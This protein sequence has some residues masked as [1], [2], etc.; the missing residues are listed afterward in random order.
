[1]PCSA[2]N[3]STRSVGSRPFWFLCSLL[4]LSLL[5]GKSLSAQSR[6]GS[7]KSVKAA[8]GQKVAGQTIVLTHVTVID[9]TGSAPRKDVSVSIAGGRIQSIA[10]K[11]PAPRGVLVIPAKGKFVIPG[12][13][14]MHIHL[15]PPEIFFPMLLANGITGVRDMF[16]GVPLNTIR[17][18]RAQP[19][20]PHIVAGGFIDG[21][22]MLWNGIPPPGAFAV[23]NPDQARF[24]VHAIAGSGFDFVKVYSSVPRDAYFALA[25][26]ARAVGI[27]F[28]GHVPEEVSPTEASDAGQRSQEHLLNILLACSTHEEELRAERVRTMLDPKMSG[29][30]RMRTL[31]FPPTDGLLDSYSE[32]K[33][34]TLFETFVRNGTWQTPTLVVLSGFARMGDDDFVH[35]SRR[36][37]LLTAWKDAW[38]PRKTFFLRDLTPA[39]WEALQTRIRALLARHEKLVGDMHRAGVQFLAGTDTNGY[40][41][42]FPGSGLH[43]EL[44]L[45]V[46]SGLSP[47]QALQS[48]TLNPARYFGLE[49]EMGTVEAGKIAD[50]VL[51]NADPLTD[52]HNSVKI[53]AVVKRGHYYSRPD[54]DVLAGRAAIFA[55]TG[56]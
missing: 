16:S 52:I 1:V 33:A 38:D 45:L 24:A 8:S 30:Q 2:D 10:K 53:E 55:A 46:D 41:P 4:F 56:H 27:P 48:A 49:R 14:D 21:P 47:L 51:L 11:I 31:A 42:V 54:L 28:A 36:S 18:W 25:Q 9:M 17:A 32:E 7:S 34:A 23:A 19:D 22:P 40:N 20:S 50:L 3:A 26:E 5:F 35:D 39:Q 44:A 15:G 37:Y 13:W 43:D 6:P 29:E 12:L